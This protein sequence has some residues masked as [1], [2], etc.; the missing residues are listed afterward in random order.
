MPEV[1][2]AIAVGSGLGLAFCRLAAEAHGGRIGVEN[3][4]GHGTTIHVRLPFASG[5][6]RTSD[7]L[8]WN[9]HAMR[10]LV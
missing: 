7:W 2:Q 4:E 1:L 9:G 3:V 10:P 6:E 5:Q 8:D